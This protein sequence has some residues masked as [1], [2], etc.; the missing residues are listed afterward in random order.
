MPPE[1]FSQGEQAR[2]GKLGDA[3]PG[4][5][6][7]DLREA[8]A[9]SAHLFLAADE[10]PLAQRLHLHDAGVV[11]LEL[12]LAPPVDERA[13]ADLQLLGDAGVTAAPHPEFDELRLRFLI[14]H[15]MP[16]ADVPA[17]TAKGPWL[18]SPVTHRASGASPKTFSGHPQS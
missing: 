10:E 17:T 13:F 7:L 11:N 6:G 14:M 8:F 18:H 2:R 9:E 4:Q 3:A 16:F 1:R 15:V 5:F 12:E